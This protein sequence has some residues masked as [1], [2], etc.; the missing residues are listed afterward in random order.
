MAVCDWIRGAMDWVSAG[1]VG[2]RLSQPGNRRV[3]AG[4]DLQGG[5]T[6]WYN[7]PSWSQSI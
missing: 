7:P 2:W 5:D 6:A 4:V 3:N 1:A